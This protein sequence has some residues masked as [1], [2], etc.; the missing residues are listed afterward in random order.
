MAT[1]VLTWHVTLP[2]LTWSQNDPVTWAQEAVRN[3]APARDV[4]L[5]SSGV[6]GEVT[7]VNLT[8]G[9]P[10]ITMSGG[11]EVWAKI[12]HPGNIFEYVS[13]PLST[14]VDFTNVAE[15]WLGIGSLI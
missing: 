11:L 14:P 3:I 12:V 13:G 10:V 6:S 2:T 9:G 8:P 1:E 4:R 5:H 15:P 7:L